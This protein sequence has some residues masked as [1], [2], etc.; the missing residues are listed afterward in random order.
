MMST[1]TEPAHPMTTAPISTHSIQLEPSWK[2]VLEDAFAT[3]TMRE[4][5]QFLVSEKAAGKTVY[6]RGGLI[7]NAMNSTPFDQV[8]VVIL[9][10]DP[11]HGPGQAHG[12]CFSV[13]E[14]I[15][16]PPSLVNIFKEIEQDLGIIPPKDGCLQRWA[17]Q[18]VLLLNSVL[19]VEQHKAASH[20]GKGWEF[21]TDS[22]IRALNE[23]RQNIV[24]LLWGSY[25]KKKGNF[26]D[27]QRHLVLTSPHPS[28]L[29]AHRGFFGNQHFS[30]TNSYLAKNNIQPINW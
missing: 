29:S 9:G 17:D 15:T 18:G 23:Q 4:L 2:A 27:R 5:K 12:L 21:F 14:G 25:A 8:K 22:I 26:I 30:Q 7:F 20:Q 13:P 28:P 19:T 11:Y 24:F 10:Q 1:E 6:P 3:P 16:P